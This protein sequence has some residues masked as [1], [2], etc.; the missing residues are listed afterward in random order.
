[1]SLTV[2]VQLMVYAA[3]HALNGSTNAS[4]LVPS[5]EVYSGVPLV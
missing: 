4:I 3:R 1:M 5:D 2:V